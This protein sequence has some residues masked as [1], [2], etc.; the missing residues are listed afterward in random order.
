MNEVQYRQA[1]EANRR[2]ENRVVEVLVE[3]KS[4]TNPQKLTGRTRSNRIVIFDGP[5]TIIGQLVPVKIT[6]AKT[7]NL[8]GALG[9]EMKLKERTSIQ[10]GI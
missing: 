6:R 3:G 2:F 7:F 1:L 10:G 5:E 9:Q 8:E 4:K